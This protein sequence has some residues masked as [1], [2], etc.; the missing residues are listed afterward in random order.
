MDVNEA[1]N[2]IPKLPPSSSGTVTVAL[3][4]SEK[5]KHGIPNPGGGHRV[6]VAVAMFVVVFFRTVEQVKVILSP[7]SSITKPSPSE[8]LTN[9]TGE[10]T[11]SVIDTLVTEPNVPLNFST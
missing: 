3:A 8:S 9:V 1:S 6:P 10:H 11:L 5:E 2:T 7:A 4:V